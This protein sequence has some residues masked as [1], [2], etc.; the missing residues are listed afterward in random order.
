MDTPASGPSTLF[1]V[2][3]REPP[4]WVLLVLLFAVIVARAWVV[5][6]LGPSGLWQD[7]DAYAAVAG[8]LVH[9]GSFAI[10]TY[11]GQPVATAARAPLYP[12]LLAALWWCAGDV[13]SAYVFA[14]LHVVLGTA[15]VVA[16]WHL[17]RLWSLAPGTRLIAAGLVAI[18][19]ILLAESAQIMTETLAAFLAAVA[20]VAITICARATSLKWALAAG[21]LLGLCILCR[22]EFL[23]WTVSVVVLFPFLGAGSH[24]LLRTTALVACAVIVVAPWAIRNARTF[25]YP[26]VTTT[27]GGVTLLLANNASFY[28]YLRSAPWGT[29]WN[30]DVIMEEYDRLRWSRSQPQ[31]PPPQSWPIGVVVDEIGVDRDAYRQAFDNIRAE[32]GTFAYSCLVRVGR[33]WAV[34]PHQLTAD[35]SPARRAM[36]YAVALGYTAELALAGIGLCLVGRKSLASPWV[37]GM[38]LVVSYTA[39]HA[40]YWTDMRMRAP[41]ESVVALLAAAG[42]ARLA[43][44][45]CSASSL[46]AGA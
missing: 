2:V 8:H 21:V 33:L 27:H 5:H 24:R 35:E 30:G 28:E 10:T 20:L 34:L 14:A 1:L 44:G 16:A 7:P 40:L 26:V 6:S 42:V 36:R 15:T 9:H 18:D 11:N 19:P 4:R 41:L 29:V 43:A 38:L 23:V 45:R 22:P 32:P 39:V 46:P 12:L 25:G 17:G 3:N 13:T 31:W 37:W